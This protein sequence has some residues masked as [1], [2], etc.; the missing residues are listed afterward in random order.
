MSWQSL[1]FSP[2]GE[3]IHDGLLP[4]LSQ[5]AGELAGSK[6]R[7]SS[8]SGVVPVAKNP[9]SS[10][11]ATVAALRTQL[12]DLVTRYGQCVCVHPYLHTV[13]HRRGEY[14]YLTPNDAL[15]QL[16]NKLIDAEE[17][18]PSGK[19]GAVVVVL[20]GATHSAFVEQLETFLQVFPVTELQKIQRR[21]NGLSSLETDKFFIPAARSWPEVVQRDPRQH[22]SLRDV[23]TTLGQLVAIGEGYNE[24]T[25][26]EAQLAALIDK[27]TATIQA[28]EQAWQ[29]LTTSLA[30]EAGKVM[31]CEGSPAGLRSELF[32]SGSPSSVYKLSAAISW[33]AQPAQLTVFKK[34]FG[35]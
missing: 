33:I 22:N 1:T 5:A 16:G 2:I 3:N 27:K 20:Y 11:A 6:G 29:N 9:L 4:V 14:S 13:G 34:V 12:T 31:Y 10:S 32:K 8:I 24:T 7:L 18:F 28:A 19:L 25:A 17:T 21:A 15:K 26:P 23:D 30:G 35:L